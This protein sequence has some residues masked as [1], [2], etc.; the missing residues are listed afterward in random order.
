MGIF[1][2]VFNNEDEGY[3]VVE[4]LFP[5]EDEIIAE[6]NKSEKY[7]LFLAERYAHHLNTTVEETMS[8]V[9]AGRQQDLFSV[10]GERLS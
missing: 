1:D 8:L 9:E 4:S 5:S 10:S 3:K 2:N 7:K 6:V